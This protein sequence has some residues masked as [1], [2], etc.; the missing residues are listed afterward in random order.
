MKLSLFS[1]FAAICWFDKS[2]AFTGTFVQSPLQRAVLHKAACKLGHLRFPSK[3]QSVVCNALP[4]K[5]I[6]SLFRSE[7]KLPEV[8]IQVPTFFPQADRIIAI[9]D[10][11]GDVDALH[12]CLKVANLVDDGW[13]WIGGAAHL[14]QVGDILD[15]G[16]EERRCLQSLLDLKQKA[17]Q[18]GGAVHVLLGNHEVMNVDLDFR[19]VSPRENAWF[20]WEFLDRRPKSGSMLVNIADEISAIRFPAY[21]RER[22]Y[23]FRPGGGAARCLSKM[24]IAI[25]IGDSVFV[26]GG[27]RLQ[28]VDYGLEKLNQETAA[29]LY[30]SPKYTNYPKPKMIDDINSPI[31]SRI[32]SVPSP[33]REAEV[34]LE[35]VLEKLNAKRMVVG[36]TPQ[37][38][39]INAFV[40]QNGYEVWRTD[41]GMSQGM[42]SGPIECLEILEDGRVHVLTQGGIVPAAMRMPEA[43]GEFINVCEVDSGIC[44]PMP[45]EVMKIQLKEAAVADFSEGLVVD[46]V[47]AQEIV[48][49]GPDEAPKNLLEKKDK[50]EI[51]VLRS[52]DD[53]SMAPEQRLTFLLERLIADAIR[54]ED[55]TLTKK[56]VKEVLKKVV[57]TQIVDDY[58]E[59]IGR[60]VDRIISDDDPEY[61]K[62]VNRILEKYGTLV[63]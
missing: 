10:V 33:K 5:K 18:A 39:G 16:M 30:G 50:A 59:F 52:L 8:D 20:G 42:M 23:A 31:W 62:Y 32:Y 26:H 47:N 51:E 54:R 40:T 36:H 46:V 14:V 24:P 34:E 3:R 38:R 43:E 13:N 37:L 44:T 60:E 56:T 7:K 15:R 21:M 6:K 27:L 19:Y 61:G 1:I 17:A 11:H 63:K 35:Q 48:A 29:W 41:T 4:L 9:G 28:H 49:M 55:E 22:V 25:Q 45:E 53:S 2:I 57:G 58:A 12:E